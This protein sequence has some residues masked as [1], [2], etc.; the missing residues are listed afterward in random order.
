MIGCWFNFCICTVKS[1]VLARLVWKHML[2]FSVCLWME[3]LMLIYCDLLW[4][5]YYKQKLILMTLRYLIYEKDQISSV[6]KHVIVWWSV[7]DLIF[8]YICTIFG[9]NKTWHAVPHAVGV[10]G[11]FT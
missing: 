6:W 3:N 10:R 8:V 9:Q 5:S 4:F 1:Q 7:I 2:A 11:P